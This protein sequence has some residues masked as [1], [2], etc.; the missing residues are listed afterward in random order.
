[1]KFI[2]TIA[3]ASI[4]CAASAYAV[5]PVKSETTCAQLGDTYELTAEAKERF[6]D[7][8]GSCE[9]VY[10]INGAKYVRVQAIVRSRR[11]NTVRL[12]LPAT[13]HT[14]E[15][16]AG[17]DGRV[18]VGGRKMRV[19]TLDRRDEIGIYLSV[20]KFAQERVTEVA[21][22]TEDDHEEAIVVAPVEEVAALPTTG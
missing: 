9:G 3:V 17:N 22:A 11:G 7:L 8:A 16:T 1:M 4:F 5:D 15:V 13:D 12:Y 18:W 21:F 20:D 10:V 6:A 2:K 19:S 14:F